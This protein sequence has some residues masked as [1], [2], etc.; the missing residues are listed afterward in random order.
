MKR[1]QLSKKGY[2]PPKCEMVAMEN[3][4]FIC[5]SVT[6]DGIATTEEDWKADEWHGDEMHIGDYGSVLPW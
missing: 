3:E 1:N 5:V 6:P 4:S 2:L